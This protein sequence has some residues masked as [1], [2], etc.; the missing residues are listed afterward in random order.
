VIY[1]PDQRA[2]IKT[3][4]SQNI[5]EV[6]GGIPA[7]LWLDYRAMMGDSGDGIPGIKGVGTAA[8]KKVIDEFGGYGKFYQ[9][10]VTNG[11]DK[12]SM[13]NKLIG[14]A[15][16]FE[17]CRRLMDLRNPLADMGKARLIPGELDSSAALD[18]LANEMGCEQG[19]SESVA[20][21]FFTLP[22]R[23]VADNEIPF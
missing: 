1:K 3:V 14:G 6:T 7:H 4:T 18:I 8:A 17:K 9:A 20:H 13:E 12:T 2:K 23:R 15:D 11:R 22:E 5:K 10:M 16:E 21:L 19:F